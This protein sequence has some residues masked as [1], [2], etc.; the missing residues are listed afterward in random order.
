[1]N[2]LATAST[3]SD[4]IKRRLET[5]APQQIEV[6]DDSAKHAGHA[7][8]AGGGH[9]DVLIVSSRFENMNRVQRHRLVYDTLRDLMP[10]P[11]HALSIR[12]LV[13]GEI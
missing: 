11:V 6:Y 7:S 5:L 10:N 2:A 8:A 4:L 1:M 12:A 3:L 9:F 13:P